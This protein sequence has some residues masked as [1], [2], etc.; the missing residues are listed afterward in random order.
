MKTRTS[1]ITIAASIGLVSTILAG[2]PVIADP[3]TGST[4]GADSTVVDAA[5]NSKKRRVAVDLVADTENGEMEPGQMLNYKIAVKNIGLEPEWVFI[6]GTIP[7]ATGALL[8]DGTTDPEV[9]QYTVNGHWILVEETGDTKAFAYD[10]LLEPGE[11]TPDLFE[12]VA[13]PDYDLSNPDGVIMT[14]SMTME[15]VNI[16]LSGL[17]FQGYALMN[18]HGKSAGLSE[19][20]EMRW[21]LLGKP[22]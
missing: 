1:L 15:D 6:K 13:T 17:R 12:T 10:E 2:A 20:A 21:E 14:G 8:K 3:P 18:T 22:E 4:S 16:K 19:S 5:E 7:T 9:I 11:T